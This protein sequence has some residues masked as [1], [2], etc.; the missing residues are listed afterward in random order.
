MPEFALDMK[1]LKSSVHEHL[2]DLKVQS[3]ARMDERLDLLSAQLKSRVDAQLAALGS[4]V[5]ARVD[6]QLRTLR[7]DI[8]EH[9]DNHGGEMDT[10]LEE[11]HDLIDGQQE[12][13]EQMA[14]DLDGVKTDV[15]TCVREDAIDGLKEE[16]KEYLNEEALESLADLEN[17]VESCVEDQFDKRVQSMADDVKVDVQRSVLRRMRMRKR[18]WRFA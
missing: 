12:D 17:F 4:Q 10:Q 16:L 8:D 1:W 6:D 11:F 18:R 9:F 13:L 15:V 5:L 3:M 7:S 2:E 14:E